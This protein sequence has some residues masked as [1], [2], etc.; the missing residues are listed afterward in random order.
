M[1]IQEAI[2]SEKRFKRSGADD[3]CVQKDSE[4]IYMFTEDDLLA[5]DWEIKK[6]P[7][8]AKLLCCWLDGRD[9]PYPNDCA[10]RD[11]LAGFIGKTTRVNIYTTVRD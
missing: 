9:S 7:L 5:D 3:W 2:K 6:D 1:T 4:G 10:S 11:V 8:R